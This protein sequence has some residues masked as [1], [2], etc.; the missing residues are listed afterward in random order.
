[1]ATTFDVYPGDDYIPSFLELKTLTELKLQR[2]LRQHGIK[3]KLEISVRLNLI[4]NSSTQRVNLNSPA[5]WEENQ[6]AWFTLEGIAGGTGAY[7]LSLDEEF[8]QSLSSDWTSD[9]PGLQPTPELAQ[10]YTTARSLGRSWYFRRS[11]G[12]PAE[13]NIAYGFLASALAEL[14]NGVV[15]SDDSAWDFARFPALPH[16]FDTWY[17]NP[18]A[19]LRSDYAKWASDCLTSLAEKYRSSEQ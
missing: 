16:D 8:R 17:M 15:Y 1:M 5:W 9:H 18:E 6:Y 4:D 10:V 7:L 13:I 12:Q 3:A 2:Y 19:A 14:T 11:A